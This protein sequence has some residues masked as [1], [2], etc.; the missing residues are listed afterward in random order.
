MIQEATKRLGAGQYTA[1][2]LRVNAA[3]RL[4]E[5]GCSLHMI[6]S[7]TGHA[8]ARE[9]LRYTRGVDQAKLALQAVERLDEVAKPRTPGKQNSG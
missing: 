9:I 6:G 5:A 2:G 1:H 8:T 3:V 4:A 7:I